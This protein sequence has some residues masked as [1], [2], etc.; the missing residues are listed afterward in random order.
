MQ[1]WPSL[2]ASTEHACTL[3][4][5][6][7]AFTHKPCT[8]AKETLGPT[9]AHSHVH[10]GMCCALLQ[11][12]TNQTEASSR[13]SLT[14]LS[15]EYTRAAWRSACEAQL[16][17]HPSKTAA[18]AM[19]LAHFHACTPKVKS[20]QQCS[21]RHTR[22]GRAAPKPGQYAM[23]HMPCALCS[24]QLRIVACAPGV[25]NAPLDNQMPSH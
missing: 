7:Q 8:R 12:G 24:N 22:P 2:Q 14:P 11:V 3:C 17:N 4:Q 15:H 21:A 6:D 5:Q 1:A 20:M 23:R 10:R 16:T 25:R 9:A 19:Y 13:T 18:P